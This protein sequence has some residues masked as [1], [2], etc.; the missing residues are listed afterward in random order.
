MQSLLVGQ[1]CHSPLLACSYELHVEL[2]SSWNRCSGEIAENRQKKVTNCRKN[3]IAVWVI[4][5]KHIVC[6]VFKI[7]SWMLNNSDERLCLILIDANP[8]LQLNIAT[9]QPIFKLWLYRRKYYVMVFLFSSRKRVRQNTSKGLP[10]H[11]SIS[12]RSVRLHKIKV[13]KKYHSIKVSKYH[14]I[15]LRTVQLHLIKVLNDHSFSPRSVHLQFKYQ[16]IHSFWP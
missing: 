6:L 10:Q 15:S 3:W 8:T 2:I 5:T 9:F 12:P 7:I 14:S 4:P 1:I 16:S 13:S 11:H